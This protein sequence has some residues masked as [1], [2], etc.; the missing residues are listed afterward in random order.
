MQKPTSHQSPD[1]ARMPPALETVSDVRTAA[2]FL[3]VPASRK[4]SA[5]SVWAPEKNERELHRTR[6]CVASSNAHGWLTRCISVCCLC[7][8]LVSVLCNSLE[9]QTRDRSLLPFVT[10]DHVIIREAIGGKETR[11]TGVIEDLRGDVVQLRRGS[12]EP[13]RIHLREVIELQFQKSAD[14]NR[15][16][17]HMQKRQWN[18]ALMAFD[19]AFLVEH[20]EWVR[21]EL[22][23]AS[24]EALL[25]MGQLKAVPPRIAKIAE[26]DPETR[27]VGLLPMVWDHRMPTDKRYPATG[28]DLSAVSP[29]IQLTAASV[30][31]D[32]PEFNDAATQTLTTLRLNAQPFVQQLAEAQMWRTRIIDASLLKPSDAQRMSDRVRDF[33]RSIRSG[34]EFLLGRSFMILHDYDNA[35]IHLMWPSSL[36]TPDRY[37]ASVSLSEAAEALERS[38]RIGE[39]VIARQEWQT[40]FGKLDVSDK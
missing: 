38:G 25:A 29:L 13:M 7:L 2:D 1:T 9:A 6:S 10:T 20:R 15:G 16:L 11:L 33:D 26:S 12:G 21:R 36:H 22:L 23:A 37:L 3:V 19:Q 18:E 4:F 34:P 35:A 14:F 5:G 40:H 30:L 17:L 39:S 27:H 8:S 32:Q 31:L 24:S 28:T